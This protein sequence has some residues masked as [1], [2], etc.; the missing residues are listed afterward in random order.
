M[1]SL[2]KSETPE[3]P[4]FDLMRAAGIIFGLWI[5][6]AILSSRC[7]YADGSHEFIRVLDAQNFALLM[8]SRHFAFYIYEFPLVLAIKLGVTDLSWLRF[9][10]GLGCFLPWP[11]ALFCCWRISPKNFW[12]AAAGCAAGYLNAAFMAVGEHIVAHALFW[13]ALFVLLFA[14]PLNFFA[15]AVLVA[16]ATGMLFSYESQ[17]VLCVPLALLA[18]W[19]A[20]ELKNEPG[21]FRWIIFAMAT[22]VFLAGTCIG[23]CGIFFPE[24]PGNLQGFKSGTLGILKHMGWTFGC[25]T[26]WAGL[27]LVVCFSK[28]AAQFIT[29]KAV[30]YVL[31][32]LLLV[33]GTWPLLAPGR[34]DNAVQF[35]NRS[36]DLLVPMA[37][38]PVALLARFRAHWLEPRRKLLVQFVAALWIAQ[39]LWQI[40]TTV[41]WYRE[42]VFMREFLA[43]K[44]GI[45]PLRQTTLASDKMQGGDVRPD[46]FGGRF[47]WTWPC[48]SIS[49]ATTTNINSLICSEIFLD[50][51]FI[52]AGCWQPFDPAD[53][54][55]FPR[56]EHYGLNFAGHIAALRQ[57]EASER[58]SPP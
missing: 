22:A 21:N 57:F 49:V 35:D 43:A 33:W 26:V 53:P 7:L 9:A 44:K 2:T 31:F 41:I 32:A 36:L 52:N 39:S 16:S 13:P 24:L 10:F 27:L 15:A 6:A 42:V 11:L 37:L 19:R 8:W 48:L 40:S 18:L 23:L 47:E 4:A 1:T 56:L 17:I 50:P 25:T 46:A 38:L 34:L 12:L 30:R 45:I 14:R 5:L 29:L 28:R 51:Q 20:W 3:R 54:K 55:T 58:R